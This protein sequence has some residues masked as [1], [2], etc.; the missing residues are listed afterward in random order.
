MEGINRL[1][2]VM[3]ASR[4]YTI[5]QLCEEYNER[6]G[7][8]LTKQGMSAKINH[9][10]MKINEFFVVCDIL[11]FKVIVEANDTHVRLLG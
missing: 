10:T 7:T 11:N 5:T 4:D 3:L 8:K 9:G 6:M 1:I 2:R